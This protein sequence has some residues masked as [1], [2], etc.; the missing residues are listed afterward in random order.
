MV[1][2]YLYPENDGWISFGIMFKKRSKK[3]NKYTILVL[4]MYSRIQLHLNYK[5]TLNRLP[6]NNNPYFC[7]IFLSTKNMLFKNEEHPT[8]CPFSLVN[9]LK[10]PSSSSTLS[11]KKHFS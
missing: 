4:Q 7:L 2:V 8:C 11:L 3:K 5:K 6:L 9:H 1:F 10:L